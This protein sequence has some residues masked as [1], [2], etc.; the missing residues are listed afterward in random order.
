MSGKR[1]K[2][3]YKQLLLAFGSEGRGETPDAGHKGT[4]PLVAKPELESPAKKNV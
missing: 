2:T 3:Q 1:Q 4:E